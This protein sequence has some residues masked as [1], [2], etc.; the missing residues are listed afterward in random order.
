LVIVACQ[1]AQGLAV[2]QRRLAGHFHL[3]LPGVDLENGSRLIVSIADSQF[4][5]MPDSLRRAFAADVARFA[6]DSCHDLAVF[7]KVV[8]WFPNAVR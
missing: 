5:V 4:S 3:I 2:I 8:V 1:T 7:S 6:S